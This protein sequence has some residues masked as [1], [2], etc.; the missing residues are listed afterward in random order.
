M[1]SLIIRQ[2]AISKLMSILVIFNSDKC[3]KIAWYMPVRYNASGS[4]EQIHLRTCG[5]CPLFT[6]SFN[7]KTGLI[8]CFFASYNHF[9]YVLDY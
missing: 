6:Y 7:T 1:R 2:C 3:E 5:Y 8:L 4:W 9:E